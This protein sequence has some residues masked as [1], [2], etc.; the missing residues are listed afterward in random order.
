MEVQGT[1]PINHLVLLAT[2]F[3]ACT[4][5]QLTSFH[6]GIVIIT[7]KYFHNSVCSL[8]NIRSQHLNDSRG[9]S[10]I[11]CGCNGALWNF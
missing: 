9:V 10:N 2:I 11:H 6:K 8:N 4:T 7:F 1:A 3:W 5:V